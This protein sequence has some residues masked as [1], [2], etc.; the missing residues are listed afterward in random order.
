MLD[1]FAKHC[2]TLDLVEYYPEYYLL[3]QQKKDEFPKLRN[4]FNQKIQ[5]V[6]L[7]DLKYSLI[8]MFFVAQK[9][10]PI[11]LHSSIEK[12]VCHLES[13]GRILILD[14]YVKVSDKA[15]DHIYQDN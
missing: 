6:F 10:N 13:G 9:M 2:S 1:V 7:N 12:L 14:S 5:D 3:L 8:T 15:Y 11:M 4:I